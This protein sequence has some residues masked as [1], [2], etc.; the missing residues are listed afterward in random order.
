MKCPECL[1][2][3]KYFK[4]PDPPYNDGYK[5]PTCGNEVSIPVVE[6]EMEE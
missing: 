6:L 2:E 5:C 1:N 3:M 4:S